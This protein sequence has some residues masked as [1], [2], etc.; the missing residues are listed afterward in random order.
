MMKKSLLTLALATVLP[1]TAQEFNKITIT[2]DSWSEGEPP[3]EVFVVDGKIEVANKDGN[4]ALTIYPGTE[5]VDACAQLA[6]SASGSASIQA[7]VF[8]SKRGRSVPRFGLSAH[9]LSGYRCYVTPAK[10]ELE[11]LKGD[12]TVAS[13][14]FDWTPETWLT[15]KLEVKRNGDDWT[16]SGSAWPSNG[17][18]PAAPMLTHQDKGLKGQG[19]CAVWATPYSAMPI[20]FDDIDIEIEVASE[21]K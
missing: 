20:F 15:M 8:A 13:M 12:E 19:K 6:E 14:P 3:E 21:A 5:L 2:A 18:P 4:K 16:I 9:G 17:T 11:L 7:R 10:K 1:V